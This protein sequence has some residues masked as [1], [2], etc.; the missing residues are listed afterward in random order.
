MNVAAEGIS[1]GGSTSGNTSHAQ[2]SQP[3]LLVVGRG[4]LQAKRPGWGHCTWLG[5]SG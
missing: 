1:C 5:P 3:W 4:Q 2:L